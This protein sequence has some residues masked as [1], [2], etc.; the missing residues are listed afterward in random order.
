MIRIFENPANKYREEV[1]STCTVAA[2]FFG[3]LYL[4]YKGLW[5]HALAWVAVVGLLPALTDPFLAVLTFPLVVM[6]YTFGIKQILVAR[7][8]KRGWVE[9]KADEPT[10]SLS[11][12][13]R[14]DLVGNEASDTKACP[15][16]AETIKAAAV[17]CKHC[18]SDLTVAA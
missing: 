14:A 1:S 15:Y 16:C 11:N 5:A 10:A 6:F 17:K 2:F 8:L 13:E 7:Y 3:V 18:Q 9:V 4:L 12:S